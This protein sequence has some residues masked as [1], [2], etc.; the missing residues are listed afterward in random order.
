MLQLNAAQT[1]LKN[2]HENQIS[3][4][5]V[6]LLKIKEISDLDISLYRQWSIIQSLSHSPS[7]FIGFKLWSEKGERKLLKFLGDMGIPLSQAKQAFTYMENEYV[8]D[9]KTLFN[10]S[11]EKLNLPVETSFK[12]FLASSGYQEEIVAQDVVWALDSLLKSHTLDVSAN[13]A[14]DRFFDAYHCLDG[15][16][17]QRLNP[18]LNLAK[19]VIHAS[20]KTIRAAL[21]AKEVQQVGSVLFYQLDK[22]NPD[23]ELIGASIL[24][25]HQNYKKIFEQD[26]GI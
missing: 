11:I 14:Q 13:V 21:C 23:L 15:V 19:S 18:G 9:F 5:S 7:T 25:F 10:E 4:L 1:R 26:C 17:Q 6:N 16:N 20:V 8:E 2:Q 3:N 24:N 22:C 12:T